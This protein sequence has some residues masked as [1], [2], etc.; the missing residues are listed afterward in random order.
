MSQP[1]PVGQ[2]M[3]CPACQLLIADSL[4]PDGEELRC[5][6]CGAA[7]LVTRNTLRLAYWQDAV[8]GERQA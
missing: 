7:L 5:E 6:A 8:V 4:L 3:H 1:S 2:G